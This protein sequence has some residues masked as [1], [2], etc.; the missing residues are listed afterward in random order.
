MAILYI[1]IDR[2][3]QLFLHLS[4]CSCFFS[5]HKVALGVLAFVLYIAW[6]AV[7][8]PLFVDGIMSFGFLIQCTSFYISGAF[9]TAICIIFLTVYSYIGHKLLLASTH[10]GQRKASLRKLA[11]P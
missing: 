11:V 4:Y 9:H 8:V 2:F 7:T 5:K 10:S 3:L 6:L 1:T